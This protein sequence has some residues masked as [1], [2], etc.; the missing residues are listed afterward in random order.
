MKLEPVTS[1]D[2]I[3]LGDAQAVW[4]GHGKT[5][6]ELER[7]ATKEMDRIAELER[8]LYADARFALLIVLQGRDASG[9]DGTIRKVFSAV[10]P[11]G[12]SVS[13]FKA[14]TELEL[15]H[16]FLWRVHQQVPSRGMIGIFNRSHYEDILV[17]R[18]H[19]LVP[20]KVWTARYE[21]IN[22]F[23]RML[24]ANGVVILKFMLHVSR[25]E[26]RK[27][28][29]ERL[30]DERKNWKFRPDDLEDRERWSDFTKAYRGILA[31]TSTKW[32]PWYVVPADDKDVR[33]LLVA[34]T[35]ADALDSLGL[36]YPK[37]DPSVVGLKIK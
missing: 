35:I 14:P 34:R 24:T 8:V 30:S 25:D 1:K 15:H 16:D 19:R 6:D 31:H 12:C 11:Q 37:A 3:R 20:K 23:E 26:Q 4:P 7:A 5:E 17:P 13:S 18:V 33:D 22:E 9:K 28:L 21:Q 29:Q 36:R 2:S 27:R 32:A 10:N